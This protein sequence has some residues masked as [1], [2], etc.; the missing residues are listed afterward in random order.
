M[1][2]KAGGLSRQEVIDCS[3]TPVFFFSVLL[4]ATSVRF[5]KTI[6]IRSQ[7]IALIL[8]NIRKVCEVTSSCDLIRCYVMY[9][10]KRCP[11]NKEEL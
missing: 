1:G 5:F 7:K 4:A 8:N 6:E 3:K 2:T 9:L 10:Y 11:S